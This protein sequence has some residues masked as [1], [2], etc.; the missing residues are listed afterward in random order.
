MF[1]V[2]DYLQLDYDLKV[3]FPP[4]GDTRKP[5]FLKLNPQHTIPVYKEGGFVINESRAIVTYL[6]SKHDKS[7]K[8][9]PASDH[10]A[11][12]TVESR[13]YF[14]AGTLMKRVMDIIVSLER[15]FR[16]RSALDYYFR[17]FL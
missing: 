10:K 5:E 16:N 15:H 17:N 13:L 7:G 12:A 2:L 1:T 6:A 14:D 3:V 8:L 11:R 9:L 4:N